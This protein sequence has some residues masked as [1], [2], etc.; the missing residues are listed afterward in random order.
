MLEHARRRKKSF[1][2]LKRKRSLSL[3]PSQNSVTLTCHPQRQPPL[4]RKRQLSSPTWPAV[5]QCHYSAVQSSLLGE[6]IACTRSGLCSVHFTALDRKPRLRRRSRCL[7]PEEGTLSRRARPATVD[8]KMGVLFNGTILFALLGA[9]AFFFASAIYR[10]NKDSQ[11]YV[12]RVPIQLLL[13]SPA[14]YLA[15]FA[16]N[17]DMQI[18]FTSAVLRNCPS[19]SRPGVCTSCGRRA[20]STNCTRSSARSSGSNSR[21][22][23]N[24]FS[25][26]VSFGAV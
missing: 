18:I 8:C 14:P 9:V 10:N 12:P 6:F 1:R 26:I 7:S 5:N 16:R 19:R 2:E 22:P 21:C 24:S 3:S 25:F 15:V 20:T 4:P 23:A 11:A 17:A 13:R